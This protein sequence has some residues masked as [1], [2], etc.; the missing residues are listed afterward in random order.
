MMHGNRL[1][2]DTTLLA[3][4]CYGRGAALCRHRATTSGKRSLESWQRLAR[5]KQLPQEL[6]GLSFVGRQE[7]QG[8]RA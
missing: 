5:R 7:Q 3:T 4:F 2:D 6:D 8:A 1:A